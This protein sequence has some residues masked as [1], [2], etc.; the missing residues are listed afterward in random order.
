MSEWKVVNDA[1]DLPIEVGRYLVTI[2]FEPKYDA[3]NAV[4]I[5]FLTSSGEWLWD[6]DRQPLGGA[7]ILAWMPLPN[8]WSG[9]NATESQPSERIEIPGEFLS[10]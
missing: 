2:E 5:T 7:K 3:E 9:S 6:D 1:A 4:E 10:G 8:V